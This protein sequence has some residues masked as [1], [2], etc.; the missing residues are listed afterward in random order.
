MIPF[1][2]TI[3]RK[4]KEKERGRGKKRCFKKKGGERE[5]GKHAKFKEFRYRK[6]CEVLGMRP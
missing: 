5:V 6:R 1:H 4:Y 2:L 3:R